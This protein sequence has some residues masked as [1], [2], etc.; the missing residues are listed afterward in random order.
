MKQINPISS[1]IFPSTPIIQNNQLKRTSNQNTNQNKKQSPK[2]TLILKIDL[3]KLQKQLSENSDSINT[4]INLGENIHNILEFDTVEELEKDNSDLYSR[5]NFNQK[6]N[7]YY[8]QRPRSLNNY[9]I[10]IDQFFDEISKKT[11][12]LDL[13]ETLVSVND[14]KINNSFI[15]QYEFFYPLPNEQMGKE[16]YSKGYLTIRPYLFYFLNETKKIFNDIIIFTSSKYYYAKEVLKIIDKNNLISK[17]YSRENCT[18]C[19]N[20]YYKNLNILNSDLAHTIIIDNNYENFLYHRYN[21]LPI[22]DFEGN[23]KDI[24]LLKILPILKKLSLVN[25]VRKIIKIIVDPEN[26]KIKYNF[27]YDLLKIN[28]KNTIENISKLVNNSKTYKKNNL[29]KINCNKLRNRVSNFSINNNINNTKLENSTTTNNI[30]TNF[31]PCSKYDT[32]NYNDNDRQLTFVNMKPKTLSNKNS[33]SN[34]KKTKNNSKIYF[35]SSYLIQEKKKEFDKQFKS[36]M[37]NL[38]NKLDA[39]VSK[40]IQSYHYYTK[41]CIFNQNQIN[42]QCNLRKLKSEKSSP[43]DNL[44]L[45]RNYSNFEEMEMKNTDIKKS[46]IDN[47]AININNFANTIEAS[48]IDNGR[49]FSN[50]RNIRETFDIKK[51]KQNKKCYQ[52]RNNISKFNY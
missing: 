15:K 6:N 3:S 43:E 49:N 16:I 19:K 39:N 47:R 44:T 41:S 10:K 45:L 40:T 42:S 38:A 12:V 33:Y 37:L 20:V 35:P 31:N 2:K 26:K 23:P 7:D 36:K 1:K 13:D 18:F 9:N 48:S 24:E 22:T 51:M 27:A 50:S 17:I 29:T 52:P 32:I 11:L 34:N 5:R 28:K 46:V 8:H 30:L 4:P 14:H 25:D 21:G